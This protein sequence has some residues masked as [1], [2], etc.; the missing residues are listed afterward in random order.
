VS[1]SG[2]PTV[3]ERVAQAPALG[4]Q[5][6]LPLPVRESVLAL[7]YSARYGYEIVQTPSERI[8]FTAYPSV[9]VIL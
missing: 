3:L 2:R 9:D 1:P 4:E 5:P 8:S 7:G 6:T